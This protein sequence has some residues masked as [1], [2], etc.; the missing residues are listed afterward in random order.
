M[1]VA[2]FPYEFWRKRMIPQPME[3]RDAVRCPKYGMKAT[4]RINAKLPKVLHVLSRANNQIFGYITQKWDM[5][6]QSRV[7][8][9]RWMGVY[10]IVGL[11]FARDCEVPDPRRLRTA[12][13]AF[14]ERRV[15]EAEAYFDA[16]F[17]LDTDHF[18]AAGA[19]SLT[20][21]KLF[22]DGQKA[23]AKQKHRR[24]AAP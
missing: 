8:W 6:P 4:A 21:V 19:S 20:F 16:H 12:D 3:L 17:F 11:E 1:S 22:K 9:F 7:D 23:D 5:C 15:P 13:R 2:F 14:F 18:Y 24:A 10:A